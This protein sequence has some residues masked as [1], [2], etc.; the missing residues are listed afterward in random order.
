MKFPKHLLLLSII[1]LFAALP[2]CAQGN[3]QEQPPQSPPKYEMSLVYIFESDSPEFIFVIGNAGFRS[4]A[5]LKKFL[6]SLPSGSTLQWSPGCIRM[7]GEPLL[8]SQLEMEV[9]KAF[10][11]ERGIKFILV[12][13]G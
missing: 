13:S 12:P 9:F 3:E 5:A 8:S 10:C 2:V 4:V 1:L 6:E 7:G 11:V